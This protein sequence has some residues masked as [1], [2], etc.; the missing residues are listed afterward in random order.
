MPTTPPQSAESDG[1]RPPCRTTAVTGVPSANSGHCSAIPGTVFDPVGTCDTL[2]GRAWH[3]SCHFTANSPYPPLLR[4][5]RQAWAQPSDEVRTLTRARPPLAEPRHS[6][7]SSM[8]DGTFY[9][10]RHTAHRSHRDTSAIPAKLQSFSGRL[11]RPAPYPTVYF[12]Q[13]A[14]TAHPRFGEKTTTSDIYCTCSLPLLVSI[15]GEAGSFFLTRPE[16]L[17]SH[18]HLAIRSLPFDIGTCLNH[19]AET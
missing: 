15:K 13:C 9:S 1:V 8:E 10:N 16:T 18:T 19:L 7:S 6:A 17:S 3:C 12:P 5:P 2:C 14:S 11:S 4:N